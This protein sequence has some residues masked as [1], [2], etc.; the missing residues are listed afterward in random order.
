MSRVLYI[1]Y[2]NPAGYPPLQHGSRILAEAGWT[3]LFL[4]T[5]ASGARGL[6]FPEHENIAVR[7]MEFCQ[8]GWRQKLHYLRFCVWVLWTALLWRPHWIYASD[9][10][11]CPAAA[12]LTF[13]PGCRV[14]YHE[15]DTPASRDA[16]AFLSFIARARVSVARRADLCVLPNAQRLARF[17][18][19]SG[20]LRH[21]V[22]VWNCPGLYEIPAAPSPHSQPQTWVLYHGTIVPERISPTVL[23]ALALLPETVHLRVVGYETVGAPGYVGQLRRKAESLGLSDRVEFLKPVS[24]KDLFASTLRSDIGL[25]LIPE[26]ST[27]QNF[28]AMTGA[29]NKVFDYLACG[30]PVIVSDLPDW[31]EMFVAP[32]YGFACDPADPAGLAAAIRCFIDNPARMKKMGEAGRRRIFDEWNYD[33]LFQ[34]VLRYLGSKA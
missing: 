18:R 34:P 5:G 9:P 6:S 1:Q 29:S 28:E 22:C 32:G 24:R 14:V 12:L 16:N 7:R 10:F 23:D 33:N 26:K 25:A 11:S 30:L 21:S 19:E 17:A 2:T 31:R 8:P 4:G 27:D 20:P 3:V 15:H 13:M